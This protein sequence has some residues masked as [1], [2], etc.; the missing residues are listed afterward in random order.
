[1]G[2]KTAVKTLSESKTRVFDKLIHETLP[3]FE[4]GI[5]VPGGARLATPAGELA[6]F[7]NGGSYHFSCYMEF[8]ANGPYRGNHYHVNKTETMYVIS[9]EIEAV[10][11]DL[12]TQ[13][14]IETVLVAGDLV[15]VLP[16]MVHSYRASAFAQ[17]VEVASHEYDPGDT[18]AHPIA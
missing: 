17:A 7:A 6:R 12:D 4:G 15:T 16:R 18:Y 8:P 1:M 9:G 10:Y 2:A 3:V 11:L 5:P 14:R 13:E